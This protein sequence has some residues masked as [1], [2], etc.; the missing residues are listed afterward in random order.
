LAE[1]TRPESVVVRRPVLAAALFVAA[2]GVVVF[3]RLRASWPAY[4][5]MHEWL[6]GL[7]VPDAVRRLDYPLLML[8]AAAAGALIARATAGIR[9]G[10]SLLA[11]RPERGWLRV[12]LLGSAPVVI[13]GVVLMIL[14][15]AEPVA[16]E[17]LNGT[18]RAPVV[19]E[20]FFRGLL[21]AVA[22]AVLN[23]A[24]LSTGTGGRKGSPGFWW[25]ASAAAVAFGMVH[26]T[27]TG[28][29]LASG[30][31]NVLVTGVG[32]VWY[33]WLMRA[34]RSLLVPMALHAAM[35]LCWIL[36]APGGGGAAGGGIVENVLR[37][38]T[39]AVTT[40]LTIRAVRARG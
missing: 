34:W 26:V 14:R 11:R 2:L 22:V 28:E 27:W 29:G 24:P 13:G 21:V 12:V 33:A 5:G 18:V 8:G 9:V 25:V 30:W 40:L 10:E 16:A 15:G 31:P 7:G 3:V 32:G 19:E 17:L 20:V 35:N 38:A 36:A 37:A 23:G 6:A 39:I 1:L 4:V